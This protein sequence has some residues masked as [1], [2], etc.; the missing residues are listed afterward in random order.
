LAVFHGDEPL[1]TAERLERLGLR[2]RPTFRKN[3]LRPALAGGWIEMAQ[4]QS[5]NSPAQKYR[6]TAQG[7]KWRAL[8]GAKAAASKSLTKSSL[9]Q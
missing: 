6:L 7:R 9:F 1:E 8:L 4:P 5:P 2:H 3:D